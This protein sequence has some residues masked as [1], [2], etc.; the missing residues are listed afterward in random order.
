[1]SA[2]EPHRTATKEEPAMK[3]RTLHAAAAAASILALFALGAGCAVTPDSS[4]ED[5]AADESA[6][7][8]PVCL[9]GSG[10]Y[11][12]NDL[13]SGAVAS[14][15]YQCPGVNKAPTSAQACANGC[16]VAPAGVADYCATGPVCLGT[17][18]GAYCGNDLMSGASAG[19]LYQCPGANKAPTSSQVCANG[20]LVA[21]PGSPDTCKSGGGTPGTYKLPW[22]AGTAMSLTQDCNDSCCADHVGNDKYAYDFADGGAFDVVAAR[23]GT[24]THVKIN[25]TSGCGSSSCVG[26]A[27]YLVVDHGDGTQSTYLHLQGGSLA[28]GVSC[29]ATVTQGQKLARSGTTGW[30]TGIHLHFEVSKS[31]A[32]APTCECGSN[33]QGCSASAVT[34]ANFWPNATYP[35]VPVS[36]VEWPAAASCGNRRI[37]M[38]ASQN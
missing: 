33:G 11:C 1:M 28:A 26:Q 38:P 24:V 35:T 13:M 19:T 10:A 5:P 15:L 23:G 12:G 21:P 29:G 36:F 34:W 8:S 17:A 3:T 9:G 31:H 6:L 7:T 2:T 14:T 20:C 32:G 18:A 27:N 22:H 30:S 37:T 16:V 4:D 25:S